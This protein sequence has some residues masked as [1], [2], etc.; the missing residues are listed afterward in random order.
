MLLLQGR[1][2]YEDRTG[3]LRLIVNLAEASIY[4]DNPEWR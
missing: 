2:R 1:E 4:V 3:I